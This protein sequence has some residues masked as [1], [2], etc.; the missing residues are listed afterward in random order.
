MDENK[1]EMK[2][3]VK[4]LESF[5]ANE[6]MILKKVK[7]YKGTISWEK[8]VKKHID[9]V[10]NECNY[11]LS[12]YNN[13]ED[14]DYRQPIWDVYINEYVSDVRKTESFILDLISEEIQTLKEAIVVFYGLEGFKLFENM[15]KLCM[16]YKEKINNHN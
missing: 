3:I 11:Y 6:E 4:D 7:Q 5:I 13:S 9:S 1:K 12:K 14:V 10:L 16:K 15:E 2:D 8:V